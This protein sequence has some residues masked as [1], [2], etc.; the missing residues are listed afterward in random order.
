M[1]WIDI[2]LEQGKTNVIYYKEWL[3]IIYAKIGAEVRNGHNFM[4][5]QQA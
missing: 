4:K 5:V 1:T 3:K 2:P